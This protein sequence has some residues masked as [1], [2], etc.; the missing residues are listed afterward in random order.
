M[1]QIGKAIGK[2]VPGRVHRKGTTTEERQIGDVVVVGLVQIEVKP[3]G[4]GSEK[5]FDAGVVVRLDDQY[6]VFLEYTVHTAHERVR[7]GVMFDDV[8]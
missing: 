8:A 2:Q 1:G 7:I 5:E 3:G 6:A 4:A